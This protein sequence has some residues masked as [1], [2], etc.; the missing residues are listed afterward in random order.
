[1]NFGDWR[2]LE[3]FTMTPM[4]DFTMTPT[5]S[6]KVKQLFAHGKVVKRFVAS[7]YTGAIIQT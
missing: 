6:K 7:C 4:E 3:G 1:M 5:V 2:T